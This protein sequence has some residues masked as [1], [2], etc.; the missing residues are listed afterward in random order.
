MS[1]TAVLQGE[2]QPPPAPFSDQG[3]PATI[4]R[5]QADK[6]FRDYFKVDSA[7]PSPMAHHPAGVAAGRVG[8]EDPNKHGG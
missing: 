7:P 4:V 1:G 8:R 6:G 2:T 5:C 3:D